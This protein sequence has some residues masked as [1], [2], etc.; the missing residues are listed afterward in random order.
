MT[1]A[2]ILDGIPALRAWRRAL[3][4][5]ETVGFV[6]TMGALH[7]GHLEL[8]RRAREQCDHVAVSVFVN[9]TQFGPQ[10][11]LDTYPRDRD[12]DAAQTAEA[13][14]DLT[15]FTTA[16]EM[17]PAGF[18]TDVRLPRLG[19]RL[20]GI[21]RPRHFPGVA[22]VVLKLFHLFE[23]THAFFGEKDYQQSVLVRRMVTDLNLE[24]S[25]ET[26]SV[27]RE[28][29]GLARSSRNEGLSPA[30]RAAAGGLSRGLFAAR[31]A[32]ASGE[33]RAPALLEIALAEMGDRVIQLEYLELID[34]DTLEPIEA[35]PA[36]G[37]RLL[38][39][40]RVDG[41]R[42]IDNVALEPGAAR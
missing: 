19:E 32:C 26:I 5:G 3:R 2:N 35:V 31:D 18:A 30:G 4:A 28:E 14:A 25:V 40:A 24:I 37:A 10:E 23:P 22:L 6:P 29:N 12:G 16:D 11:D 38:V 17:Y 36:A 1:R 27:V 20:C 39:A 33:A 34:R 13:G 8:V 9:P 21:E 7:D 41:V 42:L 15:W